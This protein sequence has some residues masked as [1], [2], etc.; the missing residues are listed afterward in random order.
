MIF[1]IQTKSTRGSLIVETLGILL[2]MSL[3][4]AVAVP[5]YWN[6]S[7]TTKMDRAKAEVRQLA[8]AQRA[9]AQLHGYYLPLQ[10][11]DNAADTRSERT[12]SIANESEN[13]AL[14]DPSGDLEAQAESPKLLGGNP[15]ALANWA[16]PLVQTKRVYL[17][18]QGDS[19][20]LA[21]LDAS[22][23]R[24]DYPLD[25]WGNPYRFYSPLGLI[26]SRAGESAADALDSDA[27][28][29]G[30]LTKIDDRFSAFAIVSYGPDG[31]SDSATE[32]DDD[33]IYLFPRSDG[34]DG[35]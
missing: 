4:V 7:A 35:A 11:L 10:L 25:P 28:S 34:D 20:D 22:A 26:G 3:L 8:D 13:L 27:F 21:S 18:D 2:L 15:N 6:R 31:L 17:S 29:D 24:R 19:F 23:L 5:S 33:V 32:A 30:R 1:R 14:V 16:G 9:A 12:D